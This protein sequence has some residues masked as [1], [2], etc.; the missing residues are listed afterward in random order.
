MVCE[1]RISRVIEFQMTGAE[2]RNEREPKLVVHLVEEVVL[3]RRAKR[4]DRLMVVV[5]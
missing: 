4:T 5:K 3:V 1:E 2:Q